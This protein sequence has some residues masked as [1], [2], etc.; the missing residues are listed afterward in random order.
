MLQPVRVAVTGKMVGPS[1]FDV[2]EILGRDAVLARLDRAA[3]AV[4]ALTT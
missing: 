3:A 4:P 1:L 2:L